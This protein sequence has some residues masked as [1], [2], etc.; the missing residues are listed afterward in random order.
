VRFLSADTIF[1]GQQFLPSGSILVLDGQSRLETILSAGSI[2][3]SRLERLEGTITPGFV[4]AHCHLELSH[5]RGKI[6]KHT[7]IA[8]FAIELMSKRAGFHP[9]EVREHMHLADLE[10]FQ[11]GIVAVGDICNGPE[12]L[13]VKTQGKLQYHSFVELIGLNPKNANGIFEKGLAL[14]KKYDSEG[15]SASVVPHAPY[16]VSSNL[17]QLISKFDRE[18]HLP[19][20]IHNQ[21][22]QAEDD[23]Y[24]GLKGPINALYDFLKL[25]ISYFEAPNT[26]SLKHLESVLNARPRMFVHNTFTS[27]EEVQLAGDDTTYWCFCPV[28]NLYIENRLPTY[29]NF[30]DAAFC[31]GTDSLASNEALDLMVEVNTMM[32]NDS[33]FSTLEILK[34]LTSVAASA[35]GLQEHWGKL[36]I[37]K[38]VGLNQIVLKQNQFTFIKKLS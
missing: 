12:S 20:C 2:E 15:L 26:S 16:S 22:S 18:E 3:D 24:R 4:N 29:T 21:E 31:F 10:M 37:G 27:A 6:A 34:G 9:E 13:A 32:Q 11:N 25:D 8:N 36:M 1:D 28:A 35:I 30:K 17:V 33:T 38:N 23:F 7:G 5:L 19:I 14:Y